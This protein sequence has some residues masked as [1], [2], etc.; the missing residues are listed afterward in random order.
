MKGRGRARERE[1]KRER[2][3]YRESKT[4]WNTYEDDLRRKENGEQE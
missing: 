1:R 4:K 2:E 3:I